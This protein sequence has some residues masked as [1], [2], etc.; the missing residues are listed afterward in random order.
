VALAKSHMKR[1]I[2]ELSDVRKFIYARDNI[3]S[4]DLCDIDVGSRSQK[5]INVSL[6][7]RL[8]S[9][10]PKSLRK[11]V[12][13]EMA[14]CEATHRHALAVLPEVAPICN[15]VIPRAWYASYQPKNSSSERPWR[16]LASSID[17]TA[18]TTS[19]LRRRTQR[20]VCGGGR[21]SRVSGNPSGPM[22]RLLLFVMKIATVENSH[23]VV[24]LFDHVWGVTT[25][26]M[27]T[28]RW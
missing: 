20:L 9:K 24:G 13:S 23:S 1:V 7:R 3:F 15:P 5:H 10:A 4:I 18:T 28:W 12:D 2:D 8:G 17:F 14:L 22:T 6:I 25:A 27:F 16:A 21:F 19:A 26:C 11:I